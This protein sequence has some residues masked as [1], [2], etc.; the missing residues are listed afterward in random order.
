MQGQ[1]PNQKSL[2]EFCNDDTID[3]IP[4]GFVY[5][6]PQNGTSGY[7]GTNFGNA[8][9]ASE[10][11]I[12]EDG[13][14]TDIFNPCSSIERDIPICQAK[15]KKIL[16]SIGG[17]TPGNEFTSHDAATSFASQLWTLFG[18]KP[19]GYTGPRPFGDAIVD[20]FDLDIEVGDG[21][22]VADFASALKTFTLTDPSR[23]YYFSAPPQCPIPE[24]RLD[25]ALAAVDFDFVYVQFYNNP[26]CAA[27]QFFSGGDFNWDAW[28]KHFLL[29]LGQD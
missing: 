20:G 17:D 25:A 21:S 14:T 27:R 24:A 26:S 11:Y 13:H 19:D 16:I 15:G 2:A 29:N 23:K 1:G 9:L 3:I 7:P 22:Y 6:F 10:Y 28:G 18:P 5:K 8:C 4:I 12:D